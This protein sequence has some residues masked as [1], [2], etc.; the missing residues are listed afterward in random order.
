ME[1]VLEYPLGYAHINAEDALLNTTPS[2]NVPPFE[3]RDGDI[4]LQDFFNI[5]SL[6]EACLLFPY[7]PSA[8]EE[9][10]YKLQVFLFLYVA[11]LMHTEKRW[12]DRGV[13]KVAAINAL[14][15]YATKAV[16]IGKNVF[17]EKCFPFKLAHLNCL[18]YNPIFE[19]HDFCKCH[20]CRCVN[21]FTLV[22]EERCLNSS[23]FMKIC[24]ARLSGHE[25]SCLQFH[26]PVHTTVFPNGYEHLRAKRMS[27]SSL[28]THFDRMQKAEEMGCFESFVKGICAYTGTELGELYC[29]KLREFLIL[30]PLFDELV[31]SV[32]I[33]LVRVQ[34]HL[35]DLCKNG[36]I[37]SAVKTRLLIYFK[38]IANKINTNTVAREIS[39]IMN[40]LTS[41]VA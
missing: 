25:S 8:S 26:V 21:C 20:K 37:T 34:Q 29:K 11:D 24:E 16:G 40:G 3:Y 30:Q 19:R 32:R 17:Y 9:D 35:A 1:I 27:L 18:R 23:S 10:V 38:F 14:H 39:I 4:G 36:I 7:L 2:A 6:K 41:K 31:H 5:K 13:Y 33:D 28:F 22:N 15:F 12:R